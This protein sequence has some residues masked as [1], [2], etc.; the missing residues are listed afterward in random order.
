MLTI[1]SPSDDAIRRFLAEQLELPVTYEAP[2]MT[3]IAAPAERQFNVD[4]SRFSLGHGIDAFERAV[5]A[6]RSWAMFQQGWVRL[7]SDGQPPH[8]GTQRGHH[9]SIW[10]SLVVERLPGPLHNR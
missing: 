8:V 2:G 6:L 10:T 5:A 1:G 7:E 4:H 3:R 9:R